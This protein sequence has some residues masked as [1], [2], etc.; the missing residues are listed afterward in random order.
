MNVRQLRDYLYLTGELSKIV[1]D[2]S[3]TNPILGYAPVRSKSD[4]HQFVVYPRVSLYIPRSL[5]SLLRRPSPEGQSPD[6]S[7]KTE[8]NTRT[9]LPKLQRLVE[10][11]TG[12]S[13]KAS[14]VL[15]LSRAVAGEVL[16]LQEDLGVVLTSWPG[17]SLRSNPSLRLNPFWI[18]HRGFFVIE[19]VSG[20][21]S[22]S[23][24]EKKFF[25][26][27]WEDLVV[28]IRKLCHL[29]EAAT[30]AAQR[31]ARDGLQEDWEFI[32]SYLV[33]QGAQINDPSL[34][35]QEHRLGHLIQ[36]GVELFESL[37]GK[38]K[39]VS[40]ERTAAQRLLGLDW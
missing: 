35:P 3:P 28:W 10:K 14:P 21:T 25:F 39:E 24:L 16:L 31:A 22:Q 26:P 11:R 6:E 20:T 7:E 40:S 38:D 17:P 1:D 13:W 23:S 8:R 4:D 33:Y 32:A 36:L 19:S 34:D 37:G 9:W 15:R 29:A 27:A 5:R 18:A 30:Q 2:V 12:R